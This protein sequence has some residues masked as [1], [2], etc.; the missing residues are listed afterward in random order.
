MLTVKNTAQYCFERLQTKNELQA[1]LRSIAQSLRAIIDA[2]M[3]TYS[4]I[5]M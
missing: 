3:I 1:S 5:S 4:P 2:E